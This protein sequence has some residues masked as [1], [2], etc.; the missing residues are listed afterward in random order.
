MIQLLFWWD[1][2]SNFVYKNS[3]YDTIKENIPSMAIV[4]GLFVGRWH[5]PPWSSISAP[6]LIYDSHHERCRYQ[7]SVVALS[8]K[9]I[10][11]VVV[12]A[13]MPRLLDCTIQS[14]GGL[15]PWTPSRQIDLHVTMVSRTLTAKSRSPIP[16]LVNPWSRQ[17]LRQQ[18]MDLLSSLIGIDRLGGLQVAA[19]LAAI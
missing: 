12:L 14:S 2:L 18:D 3:T 17:P 6:Q 16:T 13:S 10:S 9:N 1:E 15:P 8:K 11:S 7:S 4:V 19:E 5:R